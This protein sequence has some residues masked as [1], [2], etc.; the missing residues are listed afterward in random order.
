MPDGICFL[1]ESGA[2][3]DIAVSARHVR[4]VMAIDKITVAI[5]FNTNLQVAV[6]GTGALVADALRRSKG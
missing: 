6:N 4:L 2:G 1:N 5:V 3:K